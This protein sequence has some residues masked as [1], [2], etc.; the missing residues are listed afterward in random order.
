MNNQQEVLKDRRC[1]QINRWSFVSSII[2][3]LLYVIFRWQSIVLCIT[4]GT[5][6]F[7]L[8]GF[9]GVRDWKGMLRSITTVII[10][11]AL[12]IFLTFI[13]LFGKLLH[14]V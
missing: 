3:L 7:G 1:T 6:F 11:L 9:S 4:I 14:L 12:S 10:T 13:L 5:F 8:I 2:C